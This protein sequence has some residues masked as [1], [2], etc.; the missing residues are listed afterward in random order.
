MQGIF[1]VFR[2]VCSL[3]LCDAMAGFTGSPA[4]WSKLRF[5][6][7]SNVY[8]GGYYVYDRAYLSAVVQSPPN[9]IVPQIVI[10]P[11]HLRFSF[12]TA[13]WTVMSSPEIR[14]RIYSI[15]GAPYD[16]FETFPA[17]WD[18][19]GVSQT[20]QGVT[21]PSATQEA[22]PIW[23]LSSGTTPTSTN[24]HVWTGEYSDDG[25]IFASILRDTTDPAKVY[26]SVKQNGTTLTT[27]QLLGITHYDYLIYPNPYRKLEVKLVVFSTTEIWIFH[28]NE[29]SPGAGDR[30]LYLSVWNGST[31]VSTTLV[32][33]G[34]YN[35]LTFEAIKGT[36]GLV[37]LIY[38]LI[39]PAYPSDFNGPV[40]GRSLVRSINV[41]TKA[42]SAVLHTS[43]HLLEYENG[44]AVRAFSFTEGDRLPSNRV[45]SYKGKNYL[46][47]A[48]SGHAIVVYRYTDAD[49]TNL[50]L[51]RFGFVP[52]LSYTYT[53]PTYGVTTRKQYL[54]QNTHVGRVTGIEYDPVSDTA[55]LVT[56]LATAPTSMPFPAWETDLERMYVT[57]HWQALDADAWDMQVE[58]L[59]EL[60]SYTFSTG[61]S[62]AQDT[63]CDFL[64]YV[65][66]RYGTQ[67]QG[68]LIFQGRKM[69]SGSTYGTYLYVFRTNCWH[70]PVDIDAEINIDV[71]P[72][73]EIGAAKTYD[74]AV[75]VPI[76]LATRIDGV[77]NRSVQWNTYWQA[78]VD[79]SVNGEVY[80]DLS[81]DIS[82]T[83]TLAT[84]HL[85]EVEIDFNESLEISVEAE[86]ERAFFFSHRYA[87]VGVT[88]LEDF[89]GYMNE[90]R[91][92]VWGLPPVQIM[93]YTP[94]SLDVLKNIDIAQRH[95]DN[96]VATRWYAHGAE[97]F[98]IG[99]QTAA[100]R[101]AMVTS[102]GAENIQFK[103]EWYELNPA[104]IPTA[105]EVYM[106]WK[107]SPPHYANMMTDWNAV[108]GPTL[109][110]HVF[111]SLAFGLGPFPRWNGG[112]PP[113]DT[114][115]IVEYPEDW[116]SDPRSFATYWTDNFMVI[117]EAQVEA[118]LVERWQTDEL[119]ALL[120]DERWSMSGLTHLGNRHETLWSLTLQAQHEVLYGSR[121]YAEHVIQNTHSVSAEHEAVH[122]NS[123]GGFPVAFLSPYSMDKMHAVAGHELQWSR[124]L[125]AEHIL[126]YEDTLRVSRAHDATYDE[127]AKL[128][129]AL[130]SPYGVPI[131]V[132]GAHDVRYAIQR[133]VR[134]SHEV[135]ALMGPQARVGHEVPYALELRNPLKKGFDG[136]YDL[137][138]GSAGATFLQPQSIAMMNG[139]SMEIDDGYITCDFESPGYTFEC[140]VKD[141][142]FV[143]GAA[144]GDRLDVLFEGTPYVF[145]LSNLS[146]VSQERSAAE[147]V[148]IKGL[149]PIFLLDAP[150]AET[151]TYAPDGAKL[152]S[153]VIQEALG[154]FVDF[155][156]HIDWMVPYGRAQ[157]T[158]QTPLALVKG[159]LESVGSRLLSNPD[160]SLYALARY[161]V[162]FDAIPS[163]VP[164][165]AL[166][167]TNN[168]FV[169][170][171]SY[172]YA[173]GY[174]RFRVRDSDTGY[175]DM[176]E[177]DQTTSIATV[178]VSP[179][180]TSWRLD[181]T[182]TP[183]I[184]L[185]AQGET[186][187]EKEE[188]WDFQSGAARASYPILELVSLTWV[189]DSLGGV[190]FE[191]HS[192]KVTA[193]V[194]SNFGYGLAKAV[195]RT[196]CSKFLLTTNTPIEA[197]QLIIVE[198]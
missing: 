138:G 159:F 1:S 193:P 96:M 107:N 80:I 49:P 169:K 19:Y 38:A 126:V 112:G 123:V 27:R 59:A 108:V 94:Y 81:P 110:P 130:V 125:A 55:F 181:C 23:E 196:K 164:P 39:D 158:S 178:W 31:I 116:W 187:E 190:S 33:L 191:P 122:S 6:L 83:G 173:K 150:Y 29:S 97:V 90:E 88:F 71:A 16:T 153:E 53:D 146:S 197:T 102:Y 121:I 32:D 105:Y 5:R 136:V 176:I 82:V 128:L 69:V 22:T 76:D 2:R 134:A 4:L 86:V 101:L 45:F 51:L 35:L 115:P 195:Y 165:H 198:L 140:G 85:G 57:R 24:P 56:M 47:H 78:M 37:Y 72:A 30:R 17:L 54:S 99:W 12:S 52:L 18:Q 13:Q 9:D 8:G 142:E 92:T 129:A 14:G 192:S 152:F 170:G 135:T 68:L 74:M 109:A 95:C 186:V 127:F 20:A 148:T 175:G 91:A 93:G 67:A 58:A 133:Q 73:I 183:G 106:G 163:G 46:V 63:G 185:D 156:R 70:D 61:S 166:D 145:F 182:T 26:L 77:R 174:N 179:Y 149:S 100:Q 3:S 118:T 104:A 15:A 124:T 87:S 84:T 172:D 180:R 89:T 28:S 160:G 171:S 144:I 21:V 132:K 177:F 131:P 103:S 66:S 75:D 41:S 143:R 151:V 43:P 194:T 7:E 114:Y 120:L 189:T 36:T 42:V 117:K 62:S 50:T 168:V 44:E 161:P 157:S 184:L 48:F 155:S 25:T 139:R 64:G 162:G 40:S 147:Q 111:H 154:V 119:F 65:P 10:R 137:I 113:W 34:A 167:E 11:D 98:P 141:L 79:T 188:L 60:P